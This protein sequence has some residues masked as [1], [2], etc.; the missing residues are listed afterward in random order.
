MQPIFITVDPRRDTGPVL[1][2]YKQ[3]YAKCVYTPVP[4]APL[5]AHVWQSIKIM[6][7][8]GVEELGAN[9]CKVDARADIYVW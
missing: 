4:A 9:M 8:F 5:G 6:F 2:K 1:A 7:D 3:R